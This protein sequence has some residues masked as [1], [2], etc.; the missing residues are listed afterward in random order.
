MIKKNT[1]LKG[2]D[3]LTFNKHQGYGVEGIQARLTF[4]YRDKDNQD[5]FTISVVSNTLGGDGLY[6]NVDMCQDTEQLDYLNGTYEVAMFH[7][8][9]ML[10]L[11]SFDDVLGWQDA[12]AITRLMR[13]AQTNGVAWVNLLQEIRKEHNEEL[14][15]D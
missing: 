9:S 11:A 3:D 14:L 8:G 12:D 7:D 15:A 4:G 13:E 6:G 5:Q 10:P 2:F 1:K